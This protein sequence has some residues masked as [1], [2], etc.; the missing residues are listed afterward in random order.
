MK[1]E[2]KSISTL[3]ALLILVGTIPGRVNGEDYFVSEIINC[4]TKVSCVQQYKVCAAD[5]TCSTILNAQSQCRVNS[6]C[7]QNSKLIWDPNCYLK[8]VQTNK[9]VPYNNLVQ[10]SSSQCHA[11]SQLL[12]PV[13]MITVILYFIIY[14]I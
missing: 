4:I 12:N 7:N 6:N 10:C 13:I 3:L 14:Y 11:Q 1:V 2:I 8:C 9:N 5:Q